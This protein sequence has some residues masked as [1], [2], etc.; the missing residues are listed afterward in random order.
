MA[1]THIVK[2]MV[3]SNIGQATP[4]GIAIGNPQKRLPATWEKTRHPRWEG[5]P[6]R[7]TACCKTSSNVSGN[8]RSR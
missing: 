4:D 1:A 2:T 7:K 6:L 3:Q 8:K 5:N